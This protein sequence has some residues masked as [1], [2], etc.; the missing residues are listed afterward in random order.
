[1]RTL[2]MKQRLAP[3]LALLLVAGCG[4]NGGI[5][6]NPPGP[7]VVDAFEFVSAIVRG[8]GLDSA[9]PQAIDNI[10]L[11]TSDTDEPDPRV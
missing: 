11:T 3:A 6:G 1:M 9:E 10:S 4:G 8:G 5:G 7:V 2:Q